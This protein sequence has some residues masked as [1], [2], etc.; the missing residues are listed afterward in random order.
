MDDEKII[1]PVRSEPSNSPVFVH[2]EIDVEASPEKVW[3]WLTN[4]TS[5]PDWYFNSSNI[6][7]LNQQSDRLLAGTKFKW[8]TF[9]FKVESEIQEYVPNTRLAWDAKA[10]GIFAYHAW[11]IIPTATGCKVI[12]EE[13][14]HGLICRLGKIFMPNKMFRYHTIWLEKLKEKA[15]KS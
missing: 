5:W 13:T 1:W 12:T 8:K 6:Q 4:L 9:G 14:Q 2:N 15:E 3:F 11:L 10:M 7:I